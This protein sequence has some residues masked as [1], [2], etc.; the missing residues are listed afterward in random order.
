MS[1]GPQR[2]VTLD[3]APD[4]RRAFRALLDERGVTLA[5][6]ARGVGVSAPALSSW[7]GGKYKG[8]NARVGRLVRRW[9]DTEA[10]VAALRSAGLDR[11]AELTVTAEIESVAA[12]AKAD[13][14]VGLVYG[15]AGSGKTW[16]LRR[17]AD[18]HAETWYL[19]MS[20]AVTTPAATLARIARAL[21]VGGAETTGARLERAIVEHLRGRH[22]LVIVDEAHQ[23]TAALLDVIRCVHDQARC[24]LVLAGNEPLW[25]RLASGERAA[26]LV[27]RIGIRRRLTRPADTDILALAERLLR[28]RP[29]GD[30]RRAV[31]QAGR[32]I[33]G[34]RAVR[35][36]AGQA[37]VAARAEGRD[38]IAPG[39]VALAAAM[40]AA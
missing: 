6:A 36:L 11:H 4:V 24:G 8:D 30:A 18:E 12:R 34:L 15:A 33:G 17:Y 19:A 7:A 40:E 28:L 38:R 21:D 29:T 10:E 37:L 25:A 27:S 35:K 22:A 16:A 14:D 31:L 1:D 3:Q 23:L 9:L 13:A 20:P 32:G 5:A 26:Q 39:D 2:V